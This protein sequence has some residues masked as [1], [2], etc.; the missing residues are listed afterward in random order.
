MIILN[1]FA[2]HVLIMVVCQAYIYFADQYFVAHAV[3]RLWGG[4]GRAI[5][6]LYALG[7]ANQN[8]LYSPTNNMFI[9]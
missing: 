3:A 5:Q 2:L 9:A 1:H 6:Y 7:F 4:K 8:N